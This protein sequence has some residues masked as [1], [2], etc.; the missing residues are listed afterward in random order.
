MLRT[1]FMLVAVAMCGCGTEEVGVFLSGA[2][3]YGGDPV[4][5]GEIGFIPVDVHGGKGAR[6]TV[7]AGKYS[8]APSE[9][10]VAGE[11]FVTIYAEK[12]TGKLISA[13]EAGNEKVEE[14]VQY[15]PAIYND[16]TTLKET[17]D[18]DRGDLD[19]NLKKG[20]RRQR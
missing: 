3:T 13:D 9:G 15:L 5:M 12:R 20:N 11:Y 6:G 17:I 14:V 19:F 18:G 2:V 10:L 7:V 4:E 16:Q 1:V 8:I